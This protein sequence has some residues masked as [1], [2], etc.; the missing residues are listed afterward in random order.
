MVLPNRHI[1]DANAYRYAYQGQACPNDEGIGKKDPETG[2]EAF[3]LRLWDG[4]I[5]RWLSP[6]PAGQ[7]SSPYLGM[8]NDPINGIDSD[9]G[10]KTKWGRFWAWV[11]N[12]FKGK[13]F[14]N[15][16]SSIAEK[17]YGITQSTSTQI[18][19]EGGYQQTITFYN[20][21]NKL[22]LASFKEGLIGSATGSYIYAK[23]TNNWAKFRDSKLLNV[24]GIPTE[25][26]YGSVNTIYFASQFLT[27]TAPNEF[28]NLDNSA[29]TF[30]EKIFRG[31]NLF[32]YICCEK[33]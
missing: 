15:P 14:N 29:M 1:Q 25:F 26:F 10:W 4:R 17:R 16:N 23:K 19:I 6:D 7:Y 20:S 24:I 5:G 28:R 27:G 21:F 30:D 22:D 11:G 12:G 31:V 18:D 3:E 32:T 8:G 33:Y 9:G 2:K 13:F